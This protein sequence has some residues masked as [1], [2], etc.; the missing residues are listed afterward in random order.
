MNDNNQKRKRV[1]PSD[2]S[3]Y[4]YIKKT[5]RN[6]NSPDNSEIYFDVKPDC[7]PKKDN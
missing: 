5:S 4:M 3:Q 2:Q 1:C 7:C 6:I